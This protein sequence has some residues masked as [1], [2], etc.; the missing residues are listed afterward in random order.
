M[1][2]ASTAEILSERTVLTHI[3][4]S[5]NDAGPSSYQ[6][7]WPSTANRISVVNM[8]V[9]SHFVLDRLYRHTSDRSFLNLTGPIGDRIT[10]IHRF[11]PE[12]SAALRRSGPNSHRKDARHRAVTRLHHRSLHCRDPERRSSG[13]SW[14]P[15]PLPPSTLIYGKLVSISPLS[16]GSRPKFVVTVARTASQ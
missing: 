16:V 15:M 4:Y 6:R 3:L 10:R 2:K 13:P 12:R 8:G 14:Q 1:R 7:A 5:R 11:L 9:W